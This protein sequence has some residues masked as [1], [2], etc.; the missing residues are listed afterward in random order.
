MSLTFSRCC[1]SNSY[2]YV[3]DRGSKK[4]LTKIIWNNKF[5]G[6]TIKFSQMLNGS[7]LVALMDK[8]FDNL[9]AQNKI[10][11]KINLL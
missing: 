10:H 1:K 2:A 6:V 11:S 3:T 9:Q 7:K 5:S 4:K 8:I